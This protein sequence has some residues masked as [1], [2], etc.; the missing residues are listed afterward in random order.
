MK[1]RSRSA[2]GPNRL[3]LCT[4]KTG[5]SD[6]QKHRASRARMTASEYASGG[7]RRTGSCTP[8]SLGVSTEGFG[9]VVKQRGAWKSACAHRGADHR[10]RTRLGPEGEYTPP[11]LVG[12]PLSAALLRRSGSRRRAAAAGCR[13]RRCRVPR[14]VMPTGRS[15]VLIRRAAERRPAAPS[16]QCPGCVRGAVLE[17]GTRNR[18]TRRRAVA[19]RAPIR[20]RGRIRHRRG[21]AGAPRRLSAAA[22]LSCP[23]GP[24]RARAHAG[25]RPTAPSD[26]RR[27]RQPFLA[28]SEDEMRGRFAADANGKRMARNANHARDASRRRPARPIVCDGP[29]RPGCR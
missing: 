20:R 2:F 15:A 12:A 7:D 8:Q 13:S 26:E 6:N 14:G 10:A 1:D 22:P 28:R 18:G 25:S 5:A 27:G 23:A 19:S 29:A 3:K 4:P 21:S 16:P 24:S 9:R 17:V 11:T